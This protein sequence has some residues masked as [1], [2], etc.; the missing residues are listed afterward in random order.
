MAEPIR[1]RGHQLNVVPYIY[2][3][4]RRGAVMFMT[5]AVERWLRKVKKL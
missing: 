1:D 5:P 4:I 3:H 2:D